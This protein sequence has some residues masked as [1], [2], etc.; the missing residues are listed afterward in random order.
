LT[1][2]RPK[3]RRAAALSRSPPVGPVTAS[4]QEPSAQEPVPISR[5][6]GHNLQ[7]S[8]QVTDSR[9]RRPLDGWPAWLAVVAI[10]GCAVEL[11]GRQVVRQSLLQ[12][13]AGAAPPSA[14]ALVGLSAGAALLAAAWWRLRRTLTADRAVALALCALLVAGLAAQQ[15]LG[16]RLQSDGFFYFA[17][18][19]S[20]INDRDVNLANDYRLIGIGHESLQTPTSTGYAH[21]AWSV[22]P[23]IVWMPFYAIG[24]AG[25]TY[26]ANRG[27]QVAVDGSPYPYRQ[28][29]CIA[30]LFYGL[31]GLWFC[32]RLTARRFTAGIAVLSTAALASGSFMLWYIVKEPTMSH[33]PS[34]CAVAA[35]VYAWDVTRGSRAAWRWAAIGLLGGLM[36]AIRWQ[37]AV[38]LALPAWELASAVAAGPGLAER[39]RAALLGAL[40]AAC[41]FAAFLP[42]LVAWNS[43]YGSP[44]AVSPLSPKM[45]WFSPDPVRMLWSSRNGLFSTS[46]VTYLAALGL[47]AFAVR[48]RYFGRPALAVFAL[49][50]YVN[51]SVEDWWGGAAVGARRFDGTIPLLAVGLGAA[52]DGLRRWIARR[53]LAAVSALLGL[54]VLWNVTAMASALVGRFG[55]SVPQ[56]FAELAVDQAR[57]LA[58]WFGHPFSYPASL[59]YAA[60]EG[61]APF[62]YDYF[63][64]P[65][66][67]DPERPYGR[68]DVGFHDEPY[69]GEGWYQADTLQD[70]TTARWSQAAAEVLLPLDHPAP[71]TVQLRVKP[72]SYPGAAPLLAVRVNGRRFGPFPLA[73]DW[74]RTDF[75][76]DAS[77]WTKGVNRL[78][79]V[80]LS[81]AVPAAVGMGGD[82]RE[83]GGATDYVRIMVTK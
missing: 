76:T 66:L 77:V 6:G 1:P 60:R 39:R 15:R 5:E 31:L 25:A 11:G 57:T 46:P 67:A 14:A 38:F 64:F 63:A 34:M 71:L 82:A 17:F 40:F 10:L 20:I 79:L 50:V 8:I 48:D 54:L 55:G 49:A 70:G 21:T 62:R 18:L 80:W 68:V 19:R 69:L 72:F 2:A 65:M 61:V 75:P 12:N 24:H 22:G 73:A 9:A 59:V 56:S 7:R 51:A 44:I 74:Q 26:L 47:V 27:V 28:A 83:L 37:N 36:L 35:F 30:G 3:S 53:P 23:A 42:Q 52:A 58:R 13:L 16:A 4:A 32:Y 45:L 41:A 78:Q 29:I 81:A 43:I 33:A